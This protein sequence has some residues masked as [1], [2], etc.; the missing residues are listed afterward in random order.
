MPASQ[1][2][3]A[4]DKERTRQMMADL[5]AGAKRAPSDIAGMPSD[6]AAQVGNLGKAAVGYVGGQTGLLRP[7]QLP[8]LDQRPVLGSEW[9][10][11]K[12]GLPEATGRPAETAG[13][14]AAGLLGPGVAGK[15]AK[16][17]SAA[18]EALASI[19]ESH[20]APMAERYIDRMGMAPKAVVY[21][22]SPH[23]FDEFDASKIGTGEGAQAY[24]HG[25]YLADS[26]AVAGE[27]AKTLSASKQS[28]A[29][30][31][32][33]GA[34]GDVDAAIAATQ[35][36]IARL[37]A[38]PN[39]GGDP[40]KMMRFVALQEEKL[41]E[42][43]KLK[44]GQQMSQPNLYK[45]DLPDE[46]IARMLDWDK[47]LSEQHPDV[48]A[49]V[50]KLLPGFAAPQIRDGMALA[51]GGKLRITVNPNLAEPRKEYFLEMGEQ[52][53]RLS[54]GDVGNLVG[55]GKEGKGIAQELTTKLGSEPF[56][57]AALKNAG[58]PGI[59][60]LDQGSRGAGDGTRNYV[61]FPGE[62]KNVKIL[63]RNGQLIKALEAPSS[64]PKKIRQTVDNAQRM[65]FP[66]I[67]KRPDVIAAEAAANVAPEDPALKQLFGVT[68]DDMFEAAKGRKGAIDPVLPGAAAN[69]K[70][71][72]AAEN[73][74]TRRNRQRLVD[75]LSEAEKHPNLT[76][77]MDAW[78]YMDPA[79]QRLGQLVGPENAPAAYKQFNSLSGMA[80]PGSDVL[81][82]INRGT[83]ANWLA[84]EG[85]FEDFKKFG[86]RAA[87]NRG[88]DFPQDMVNVMGHPYHSTAQAQA[89]E[90][91]MQSGQ[92]QM[93]S[94]KVPMY[95]QASGAGPEGFQTA[96]PVGDAHW[97]RGVGL[98]DVRT[99]K[100][101]GA[102]VSTPEMSQLGPWWRDK[103]AAAVGLESVPA[104]AR[105]WGTM[106]PQTGVGTAVGA[107]KLELLVQQIM[108]AAKREGIP[109]EQMRDL[110]LMGK[111]H[112]GFANPAA[113]AAAGAGAAG[114]AAATLNS[115]DRK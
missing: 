63:E 40:Q 97:S 42:L 82:E 83:A 59:R 34:G 105:L 78:Y 51:G 94:P 24:G 75:V 16:A 76:H 69:P 13:R 11:Q 61:V 21:H 44:A 2:I 86:G 54:E 47:P 49:A 107:P 15:A 84:N 56:V 112:A 30:R 60:Y 113:A 23:K 80:S 41:A 67:Y 18:P 36:D 92:V 71:S 53:F 95:I 5:L 77:G 50:D 104:Q 64:R 7:D 43:A 93:E 85:R 110:V 27:Y 115:R 14:L 38:L 4:R 29:N 1:L 114:V 37:K 46:K 8:E 52:R 17:A 91:F 111:A 32:L 20:G 3:V 81:T 33:T 19:I 68:R 48:Q 58:I 98:A 55:Q 70:G 96:M 109:P 102:S 99:N 6:I 65:E 31:G 10:A 26:P 103:V 12:A 22:G 87:G 62:E 89:M 90:K 39:G 79:Y 101:F 88:G 74:M 72:A 66:G 45:A 108:K 57:S 35:A 28:L 100:A 106:A 73:I 25:L 9:M